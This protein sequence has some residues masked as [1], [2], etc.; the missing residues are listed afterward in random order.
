MRLAVFALIVLVAVSALAVWG[1]VNGLGAGAIALRVLVALVV[2]QVAY[3]LWILVVSFLPRR[4]EDNRRV[5]GKVRR[6]GAKR[7]VGAARD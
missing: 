1:I 3:F 7:G 6:G 5:H 4:R 2:L